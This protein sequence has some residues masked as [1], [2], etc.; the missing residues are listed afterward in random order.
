MATASGHTTAILA[1]KVKGTTV[2][3]TT[4]EKIGHIEDVVLDKTSDRIMF[5]A[6]GFGGLMGI[7]EKFYPV[8][9]SVLDFDTEKD[10]YIVPLS[11]GEIDEA[12]AYVLDDLT[13]A[14]SDF[15][16]IRRQSYSYYEV[17]RDW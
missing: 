7:G 17:D 6:L 3:N 13:R 11:K 12:P 16:L 10:G 8:P 5:V 9:W 2:Y 14:D 4:G 1:S 15:D